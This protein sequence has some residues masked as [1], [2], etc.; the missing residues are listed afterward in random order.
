[1]TEPGTSPPP[2]RPHTADDVDSALG[3]AVDIAAKGRTK[4]LYRCG[5]RAAGL[6]MNLDR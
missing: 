5:P 1:M 4:P 3:T 2:R 6:P